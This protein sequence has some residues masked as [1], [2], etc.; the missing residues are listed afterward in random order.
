[1]T[2]AELPKLDPPGAGLGAVEGWL[3]R[4]VVFPWFCRTHSFEEATLLFEEESS[5]IEDLCGLFTPEQFTRRVLVPPMA[6][7]EDSSRFWSA[8]MVV[9]HV[10]IVGRSISKI[11]VF[12]SH[13]QVPP[14]GMDVAA[15]K[16]GGKRGPAVM[17][18]FRE[19]LAEYPKLV[20]TDLPRPADAPSFAHPWLGPMDIHRWH[21]LAAVHLRLHRRQIAMIRK[22]LDEEHPRAKTPSLFADTV[23]E[24]PPAPTG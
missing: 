3:A 19:L 1:M 6:G 2:S 20:R 7:I 11:L 10:V 5:R 9:E 12:L 8:S 15:V 17:A 24:S 18:D 21:C 14:F 4:H 22:G 16:P 13:S 23:P